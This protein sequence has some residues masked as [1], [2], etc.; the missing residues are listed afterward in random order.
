ML[1]P[2]LWLCRDTHF[3][4]RVEGDAVNKLILDAQTAEDKKQWMDTLNAAKFQDAPMNGPM[5]FEVRAIC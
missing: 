4:R 2:L 1:C 3:L 5:R